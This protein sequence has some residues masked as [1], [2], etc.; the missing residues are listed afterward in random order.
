VWNAGDGG[1]ARDDPNEA[2]IIAGKLFFEERERE[3]RLV[4]RSST[5]SSEG[6]HSGRMRSSI[7]VLLAGS[8]LAA[9]VFFV[10]TRPIECSFGT[11]C[12]KW[13]SDIMAIEEACKEFARDHDGRYPSSLEDLVAVD[14]AGHA[15]LERHELPRDPW[16][17]SYLYVAATSERSLPRI[18]SLGRD[19]KVGG[20][21]EDADVDN[22]EL[23][24]ELDDSEH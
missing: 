1:S 4:V 9:T 10:R 21:G 3:V 14:A 16:Q 18:Y 20:T 2:R 6:F 7:A 24:R 17:R 8:A 13:K 23:H 12:S 22:V 19:G 5:S 11:V 15:Y